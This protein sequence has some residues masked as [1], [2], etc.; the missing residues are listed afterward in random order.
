MESEENHQINIEKGTDN[1]YHCPQCTNVYTRGNKLKL[2][3]Q[4]AHGLQTKDRNRQ[5]CE[6][7]GCNETFYKRRDLIQHQ[8]NVH[9]MEFDERTFQFESMEDFYKWKEQEELSNHVYFSKQTSKRKGTTYLF[10]QF[11][12]HLHTHKKKGEAHRKT[13]RRR[14]FGLSK[15]GLMCPAR[16]IVTENKESVSLEYIATHSHEV[17]L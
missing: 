8:K 7:P 9:N 6:H 14:T 15:T 12:G 10:C 5:V 11:D 17:K 16:M 4:K 13:D 2:H 1:K 3:I